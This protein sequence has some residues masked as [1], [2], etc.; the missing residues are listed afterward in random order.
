[1][2]ARMV[3]VE[4]CFAYETRYFLIGYWRAPPS[5]LNGCAVYIFIYM[6]VHT[7]FRKCSMMVLVELCFAYE[8]H[9]FLIGY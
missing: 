7:S 5:R 8:T 2:V 9:Y 6:V 1:M 3:L 4:L